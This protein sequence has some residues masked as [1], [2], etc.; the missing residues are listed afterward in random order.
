MLIDIQHID[1]KHE[2]GKTLVE[3]VCF[4]ADEGSFIFIVG[5]V[6]AGKSTLLRTIHGEFPPYPS[7]SRVDEEEAIVNVLGYDMLKIKRSKVQE[8]RRKLGFV[9]QNYRLLANRTIFRNLD[10]VLR[11]TGWKNKNDRRTRI[12]EVLR[13][14]GLSEKSDRYP[15]E[16]SG[17][18]QQRAAIARALLNQPRILL[19]DEP[20]GNLDTETGNQ[21][22]DLLHHAAD[23]GAAV[24]MVTHNLSLLQRYPCS[25]FHIVDKQLQPIS[26]EEA[27]ALLQ[28]DLGTHNL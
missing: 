3:N 14:V 2:E 11:S 5:R 4:Q 9:F 25:V 12:G 1:I 18:E 7:A 16:L 23:E 20:T 27:T 19:A 24:V 8:L 22:L 26:I 17:G 13:Q 21:I 28:K 6:G 10:F 15:F